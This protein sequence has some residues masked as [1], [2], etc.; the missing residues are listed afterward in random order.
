MWRMFWFLLFGV[1]SAVGVDRLE[2]GDG[3]AGR[4]I[5]I[6]SGSVNG[7]PAGLVAAFGFHG[8]QITFAWT[9][10]KSGE[11]EN[12]FRV[13][14]FRVLTST[15]VPVVKD[16]ELS[17]VEE[18]ADG[19]GFKIEY[20]LVLPEV[21]AASQDW[22][23]KVWRTKGDAREAVSLVLLHSVSRNLDLFLREG[24]ISWVPAEKGFRD[25]PEALSGLAPW[26]VEVL[27]YEESFDRRIAFVELVSI[28]QLEKIRKF[29][30]HPSRL[31][32]VPAKE[33]DESVWTSPEKVFEF[34]DGHAVALSTAAENLDSLM[35]KDVYLLQQLLNEGE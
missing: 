19:D 2:A 14:L 21:S 31:I 34:G 7:K 15:V 16:G 23:V 28:D 24:L 6:L 9:V 1:L 33:V 3:K 35:P 13:D 10:P 27:D 11:A 25:V 22:L 8:E 26:K 30:K 20:G 18:S 17:K 5:P 29:P 32:F 4:E 12:E